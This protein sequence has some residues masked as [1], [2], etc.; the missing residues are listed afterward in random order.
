[1]QQ[2]IE[3][4]PE[5]N[6]PADLIKLRGVEK[7][8]VLFLCLQQ[9]RGAKL[10]QDLD[11]E[12]IHL[13]TRAMSTLGTIPAVTVENVIREFCRDVSGGGGVIGSIESARRMLSGFLDDGRV[14]EIMDDIS[15]SSSGRSV[16]EGFSMLNE[17]VIANYLVQER[18]QYVAAV[19][20]KVKPDV[21]ARVLPLFGPERM[22]VIARKMISM[23]P[24]P[25]P[26][27]EEIEQSISAELLSS[28]T[29]SRGPD[30]DQRMADLFNKM[31]PA[32][33]ESLSS[34][35]EASDAE[36]FLRIKAKMFTFDDLAKLD[37]A[38]LQRIIRACEGST[39][40]L[41]LR[42]AKKEVRDC[43]LGAMTQRAREMLQDE[44]DTMGPVKARDARDAQARIIDLTN[45]LVRQDAIRLPSDD[46][47]ML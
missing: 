3:T 28:A 7:A 19:M 31:D 6:A 9:D 8:A 21:A 29:R 30:N 13:L 15:G 16:W 43:F 33:F 34:K 37:S 20:S 46:D 2:A 40:P 42:G 32:I 17:K 23:E 11:D 27:L 1:M 44:M 12:E 22:G 36:A 25:R 10:M 45:D 47:E 14:T 5:T 39:M 41:A 18:D 4:N 38:S 24:L 26:V 35:L